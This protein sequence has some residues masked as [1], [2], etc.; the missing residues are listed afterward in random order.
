MNGLQIFSYHDMQVRTVQQDGESWWVLK[1]VCDVLDLKQPHRVAAR[2]DDDERTFLTVVDS[3]GKKQEMSIINEPGLY[4]VILRSSKPE[5]KSF[6]RWITHEVLPSIRKTGSYTTQ[7]DLRIDALAEEMRKLTQMVSDFTQQ[8]RFAL[9]PGVPG[10]KARRRWMRTLNEKLDEL[11]VKTG[12]ERSCILHTFYR[13]LED[14]CDVILD[15]ERIKHME[16][17]GVD[18]CSIL[19]AIFHDE[20]LRKSFECRIDINLFPKDRGW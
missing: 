3:A 5:A 4:S 17:S 14:E 19:E 13:L 12:M 1:D 7:A 20:R 18:D 15:E 16:R 8:N 9:Q 11:E 10:K 6:K 2:L